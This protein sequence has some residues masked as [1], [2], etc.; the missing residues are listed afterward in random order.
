MLRIFRFLEMI[1]EDSLWMLLNQWDALQFILKTDADGHICASTK[2]SNLHTAIHEYLAEY[3]SQVTSED[4]ED[5]LDA[6][7]DDVYDTI[8]DDD[9]IVQI[10]DLCCR[11]W[12]ECDEGVDG[13]AHGWLMKR[14]VEVDRRVINSAPLPLPSPPPTPVEEEEELMKVEEEEEDDGWTKVNNRRKR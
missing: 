8:I 11:L 2:I 13:D 9:S 6:W 10:A 14:Q 1:F 4:M 12:R 7:F 5:L 3:Q